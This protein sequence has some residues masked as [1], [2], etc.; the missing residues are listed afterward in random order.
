MVKPISQKV[1]GDNSYVCRSYS[2][3]KMVE[4]DLFAQPH[5]TFYPQVFRLGQKI[6]NDFLLKSRRVQMSL[7]CNYTTATVMI[8]N[9]GR[10]KEKLAGCFLLLFWENDRY[11]Q[12]GVWGA[13]WAPQ[14]VEGRVLVAFGAKPWNVFGIFIVFPHENVLNKKQYERN[15]SRKYTSSS[16]WS[17]LLLDFQQEN[18]GNWI[19]FEGR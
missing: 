11:N 7:K 6:A 18:L 8:W 3:E 16:Q 5:P 19:F 1:S 17:R 4:G 9:S 12:L 13:L 14:R 15:K 10:N 2:W